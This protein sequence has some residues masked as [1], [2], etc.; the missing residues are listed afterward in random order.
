MVF[1]FSRAWTVVL[2]Y[3]YSHRNGMSSLFDYFYWPLI[4]M[5]IFGFVGTSLSTQQNSTVVINL[6]AGLILWQVSFRTHLEVSRNLLQEIWD[7]NLV[8][9]FATPLTIAEWIVG[10]MMT[11]LLGTLI[12]VPYG[13]LLMKLIFNLNLFSIGISLLPLILLLVV[14]G[15]VLGF[16]ASGFL[17]YWGQRIETIVWAIGWL[18]APFCSVYYS[19]DILPHWMQIVSKCLPM[20]HA[21]EGMRY[22]LTMGQIPY[23]HIAVSFTLNV[24]YLI[25][26]L[27]FFMHMLRKSKAQGLS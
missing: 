12:T 5:L 20:T 26:A 9:F 7:E 23:W 19:V 27:G 21:F 1:K 16:I 22:A 13:A 15:W 4:D 17:I 18:P 3:L 10:L 11:G 25:L 6:I 2:R 14:S 24:V 8:N